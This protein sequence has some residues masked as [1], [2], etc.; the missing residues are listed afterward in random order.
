MREVKTRDVYEQK[1]NIVPINLKVFTICKHV[2]IISLA[3]CILH[4]GF[5]GYIEQS[6]K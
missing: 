6:L 3:R 4:V 5:L 1:G 2:C